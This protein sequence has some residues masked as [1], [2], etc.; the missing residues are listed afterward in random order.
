MRLSSY[1]NVEVLVKNRFLRYTVVSLLLLATSLSCGAW[2]SVR[3]ESA[4][5]V[6]DFG[7]PNS[8][9]N[10]V[11]E[12]S[13]LL[14]LLCGESA[15][16]AESTY[17]D[18][19]G[20]FKFIYCDILPASKITAKM[21]DEGL[22][23]ALSS[24]EYTSQGGDVVSWTPQSVTVNGITKAVDGAGE[25]LYE[26][27][28][29]G[30]KSFD[31][32]A[33]YETEFKIDGELYNSLVNYAYRDAEKKNGE[34]LEYEV[35]KAKYDAALLAHT[36][37]QQNV[38]K[39]NSDMIAYNAYLNSLQQYEVKQ[40]A[41]A[42]YLK[43]LEQYNAAKAEYDAYLEAKE[44]Y[45]SDKEAYNAYSEKYNL[46]REQETAYK[47][48]LRAL[49][50]R[51][52][53]LAII[54]GVF[55]GDSLG[56]SMYHTLRGNTVATVVDNKEE[57]VGATGVDADSVDLAGVCT[58]ALREML[59]EYYY[60][61]DE[62]TGKN[63][64]RSDSERY[65]YYVEHYEEIRKNFRDL[66]ECLYSFYSDS[67]VRTILTTYGKIERYRQFL[68]HL[69]VV[70]TSLDDV[71]ERDS[72][73]RIEVQEGVYSYVSDLL[74]E[75][76]I[77][78]DTERANPKDYPGWPEEV[79]E[80]IMPEEVKKPIAPEE[81]KSP[82]VEPTAVIEP[83]APTEVKKPIE[84]QK[85]EHPGAAPATVKMT[86]A[87]KSIVEALR[88]GEIEE[89]T[90]V[91]GDIIIKK[92]ETVSK[93]IEDLNKHH[94]RFLN[95]KD[96]VLEYDILD[97]DTLIIPDRTPERSETDEFTYSFKGWVDEDDQAAAKTP[98]YSDLEFYASYTSETKSYT[99][100]WEV[101]GVKY[102][103]TVP[104]GTIPKFDGTLDK[105]MSESVI[106]TFIGWDNAPAR[107]TGDVTYSAQYSETDRL[108]D[109]K[110]VVDGITVIEQYKYGDIPVYKGV[111]DKKGDGVYIYT[112]EGWS[113]EISAVTE[114]ASYEAVYSSRGLVF[115]S[116]ENPLTVK[117]E[118]ASYI[119]ESG[120]GS[121]D[122]TALY[123]EAL[124]MEYGITV[125][126]DTYT[127]TISSLAVSRLQSRGITR[128]AVSADES[129]ARLLLCDSTGAVID[130]GEEVILE[131]AY[132]DDTGAQL[133]C[134][135][136]DELKPLH[137]EDGKVIFRMTSG[138]RIDIIKKYS[139][140]V[141]GSDL[142]DITLSETLAEAGDVIRITQNRVEYGYIVKEIKVTSADG[143]PIAV[144][145]D[146]MTFKMPVGGASVE[147]IYERLTYKVTFWSEGE[148]ISEKTYFLGDEV[149]LPDDPVKQSTDT[150][151]YKF[152]GWT[153]EIVVVAGDAEYTAVFTETRLA[154]DT[155]MNEH[156]F[157]NSE[158]EWFILFGAV[159]A[160]IA[161]GVLIPIL[162][163]KKR[164]RS[165]KNKASKKNN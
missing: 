100:T 78:P 144:N 128:I 97:G 130:G 33:V 41:Y 29:S 55:A 23:V 64:K 134:L 125:K 90:E 10:T 94:V 15:A 7:I 156:E 86:A 120:G 84:P 103:D 49:K 139:A 11:V 79:K 34:L 119:I 162:C 50:S 75:A 123:S 142:G 47:N 44:K 89:R 38:I 117:E 35:K 138:Q 27:E 22:L 98:V 146:K 59:L 95:G 112:F 88:K 57:I 48:Y 16:Q 1:I 80:P 20:L 102:T 111:T 28:W 12:G 147:V 58:D 107:V 17:I 160:L 5:T 145:S 4:S 37:Y 14:E 31:I 133:F 163:V 140:S 60:S 25:Y 159:G 108:Y 132:Q 61:E 46:Y 148:I 141:I 93:Y 69:Y 68:A 116:M 124:K 67:G 70:V 118:N 66:Y 83:T 8:D 72:E 40:A 161:C 30:T 53:R 76:H 87:E 164:S 77:I 43:R 122:V 91:D 150:A 39:Y 42:A 9:R 127:V 149:E 63:K 81:V 96:V 21:T 154:D 32:S 54:D 115:D 51:E 104:Y 143:K 18:Q 13:R 129:G 131:Y 113:S 109:I 6:A 62:V 105:P 106:Y 137:T 85:A 153:P 155:V 52:A 74:E 114:N 157:E 126:S 3:A 136:G 2:L 56:R 121:V 73:W 158:Y 24:W 71:L 135:V 110:W 36:E 19:S 82:G 151:T 65:L 152:S 92:T 101:D 45:E 165:R 99:V 26:G